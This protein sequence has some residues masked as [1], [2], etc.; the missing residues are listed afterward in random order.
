MD[1]QVDPPDSPQVDTLI[2][3][4]ATHN[5]APQAQEISSEFSEDYIIAEHTRHYWQAY[6]T[7]LQEPESLHAYLSAFTI[8]L[9]RL[10]RDQLPP[11]PCS[12]KEI[13]RHPQY[14]G[15]R[16]AAEK[17]YQSLEKR[18]TFCHVPKASSLKPLPL[19][20]VFLYKFNTDGYLIKY[21]ARLCI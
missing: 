6:L 11:S 8:G 15:F 2:P 17:E 21:K 12:W 10:Y 20:W 16:A 19:M 14:E 4:T 18:Q 7:A 9:R 3:Y 13:L 1:L 5:T